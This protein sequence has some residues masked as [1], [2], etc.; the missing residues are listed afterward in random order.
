[1]AG[2]AYGITLPE[3]IKKFFT[4]NYRKEMLERFLKQE[5]LEI[6]DNNRHTCAMFFV[7]LDNKTYWYYHVL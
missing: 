3:K 7:T 1:M 2:L 5:S 6:F 4:Q